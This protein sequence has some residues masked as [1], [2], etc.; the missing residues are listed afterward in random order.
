MT[1]A[2]LAARCDDASELK[3]SPR[4]GHS[5][6]AGEVKINIRA[7]KDDRDLID[8]GAA[9]RRKTRTEFMLDS[10]REAA[11]NALL[12]QNFFAL[13]E[14]K[15]AEFTKALNASPTENPRFAALMARA[16]PW[17]K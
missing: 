7:R 8:R 4:A 6:A 2:L 15:W 13:D 17:D 14:Q 16:A 3:V 5:D 11:T 9:V 1:N 10:A 12:D